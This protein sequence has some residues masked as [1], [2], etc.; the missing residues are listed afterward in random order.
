MDYIDARIEEKVNDRLGAGSVE[1]ACNTT[2]T[3]DL[4]YFSIDLDNKN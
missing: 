4:L 3:K 2:R 1:D